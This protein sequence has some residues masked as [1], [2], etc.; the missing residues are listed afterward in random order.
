MKLLLDENKIIYSIE[1]VKSATIFIKKGLTTDGDSHKQW[2]LEQ[3]ANAL[4]MYIN[5]LNFDEG[6]AP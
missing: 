5:D 1:E 4:N 2:Y 3:I 6:K